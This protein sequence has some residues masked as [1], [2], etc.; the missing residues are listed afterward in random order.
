M[1]ICIY[2][3]SGSRWALQVSENIIK[4]STNPSSLLRSTSPLSSGGVGTN[5]CQNDDIGLDG[6]S[7]SESAESKLVRL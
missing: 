2:F 7:T 3:K 1:I 6:E 4:P 5:H